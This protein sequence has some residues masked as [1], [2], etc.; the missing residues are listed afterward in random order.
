MP[1][2]ADEPPVDDDYEIL[3][4]LLTPTEATLMQAC[5]AAA[6]V[7]AVV[8]DAHL[9][10]TDMLLFNAVG[11]ANVRVPR[12]QLGAAQAVLATWRAGDF[13]L[14]DDFDPGPAPV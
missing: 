1:T 11:G 10:Q 3:E 9:V 5:L 7:A 2:P 6:G 4:R 8:G 12:S 14:G 13:A